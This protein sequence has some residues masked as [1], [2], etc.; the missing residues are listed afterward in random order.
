VRGDPSVR[1]RGERSLVR[2]LGRRDLVAFAINSVIGAGIFGVPALL[3]ARVGAMSIIAILLAAVIVALITF[4]FAEVGSGF[5]QT[6]GPYLYA[7]HTFGPAVGF[8]VGWLLW[9]ARLLGFAAVI[10]LFVNY[11][12]YFAP[13]LTIGF[14]RTGIIALVVLGLVVI[15]LVGVGRAAVASTVL[16][17]G[18][19]IPLILFIV[20]GIFFV[21]GSRLVPIGPLRIPALW[22]AVLLAIYAFSGFEILS[23]PGGEIRDPGRAIPFALLAALGVV[24]LVYLGVQLV[25][26]GTLPGLGGSQRPLA[27]AAE[28]ALGR[29]AAA[30]MVGGAMVSTLGVSHTII[31]AAARLPFAMAEQ[32]QLPAA[33]AAVHPRFRTPYAGLFLSAGCVLILTLA[34]SF[35]S[36][37]TF[38][39]EIRVLTY[40]VTCAALPVLRHRQGEARS[41]FRVPGGDLVAGVSIL[42]CVSLLVSRPWGEIEQL[43]IAIGLGALL[44]ILVGRQRGVGMRTSRENLNLP[45][46]D[47]E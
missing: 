21:E 16:T 18:K 10:N 38:T 41:V 4:C 45:E 35:A 32:G 20:V 33:L 6:G 14:W 19:L 11:A 30:V 28:H 8:E 43:I 40:L 37:A 2:G 34:T 26:V 22:G 47:A 9:V 39:V 29:G 13:S 24:A 3:Y 1:N 44:F 23:I 5:H 15:N 42:I 36:A 17:V 25:A 46:K 7:L 31:L 27:D 12:S